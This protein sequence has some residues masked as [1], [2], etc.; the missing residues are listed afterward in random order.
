MDRGS[1]RNMVGGEDGKEGGGEEKEEVS[2]G[3][4]MAKHP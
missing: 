4:F 1:R 2:L 3:V